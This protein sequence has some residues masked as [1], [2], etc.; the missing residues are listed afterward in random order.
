MI[1]PQ[2]LPD[3][4]TLSR[5]AADWI[6]Q[7]LRERPNSLISL[8]AGSTPGRTYE[9]L[10]E[11]GRVEPDLMARCRW[12]KLDEWGGLAMDDPATCEH[13]L[14]KLL[15]NPLNAASRYTAFE[16]QS[17]DPAAECARIAS[18]LAAH[19]PIE[20]CVLGLGTNGHLGFN[21]P[22]DFLLPHA[23]VARLAESSMTHD[24][25]KQTTGRPTYGVTLGIGDLLH[26]REILLLVSG[27]SKQGPLERLLA[28]KVTI[29]FPASLLHLHSKVTLLADASALPTA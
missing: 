2:V 16:S 27:A 18:W 8:A 10:A 17:A 3:H 11:R 6:F 28:G 9:L 5:H 19:G 13:Q 25:L 26:A 14:R 1:E 15:I 21:E 24:M 4:E 22:A 7:R 23:H 20:V 29:Q 12:L